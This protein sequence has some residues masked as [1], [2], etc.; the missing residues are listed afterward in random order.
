MPSTL[1]YGGALQVEMNANVLNAT[2]KVAS[3][4]AQ[5]RLGAFQKLFRQALTSGSI[6]M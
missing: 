3:N 2:L 6:A 4:N 1:I 5:Q